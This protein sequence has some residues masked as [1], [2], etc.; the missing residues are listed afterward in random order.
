M[1]FFISLLVFCFSLNVLCAQK[2]V[3]TSADKKV[4]VGERIRF[5]LTIE[6][7]DTL[8]FLKSTDLEFKTD[9]N[10]KY[11]FEVFPGKAGKQTIGPF[12]ISYNGKELRSNILEITVTDPDEISGAIILIIPDKIKKNESV[13]LEIIGS[14]EAIQ[15]MRLRKSEKYKFIPGGLSSSMTMVNGVSDKSYTVKYDIEFLEKG[16]YTIDGS[17]FESVPAKMIIKECKIKV[18]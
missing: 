3:L 14:V 16:D 1:K 5:S 2:L 13:K 9:N 11:S 18:K 8:D 12:S 15:K 10:F 6:D 17:W 7:I 4:T